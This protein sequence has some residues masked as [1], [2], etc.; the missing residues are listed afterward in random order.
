MD[1]GLR[2]KV[3]L[4]TAASKG[5]G[6]A[7]AKSMLNEGAKVAISSRSE[8]SLKK[9]AEEL[10]DHGMRDVYYYPAD[11]MNLNDVNQLMD[12][13]LNHYG[14][15]DILI[16]NTGGPKTSDFL[17]TNYED[18]KEGVDMILFPALQ[19]AK[20]AIPSM[21]ENGWGRIIFMTSSWVKQPREHGVISTMY[22]SAISGLSKSLSNELGRYNILV[23]QVLPGPIWTD[24]SVNIV[25][26]LAEK[27]G[28]SMEE[29]KA[30]VAREMVVNRYGTAEEVANAVTFLASEKASFITGASLQVDGGQI[31]STV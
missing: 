31:K 27:R 24:R 26:R 8:E 15:I 6:Y 22:R 17:D 16:S 2:N 13:V 11:L 20:R 5:L 21:K 19:M 30:E 9:A 12:A 1:M 29:V 28:V 18:W 23:N 4:V 14:R 25:T 7:I 3:V 10:S